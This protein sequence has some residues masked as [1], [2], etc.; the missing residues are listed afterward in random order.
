[1]TALLY[2]PQQPPQAVSTEGLHW[3][4]NVIGPV[5]LLLGCTPNLVD[6]LANGPGYAAYSVF[7][8]EGGVINLEAMR[9]VSAITGILFDEDDEESILRGPV[10]LV[11]I[12]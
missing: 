2:L 4:N 10:L 9:A 1:M 5:S 6:V 12:N 3:S 11:Q 8:Y 7:D